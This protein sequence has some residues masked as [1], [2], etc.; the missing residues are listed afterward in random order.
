MI[1]RVTT[2]SLRAG[3]EDE[4]KGMRGFI[5]VHALN[6]MEWKQLLELSV[7]GGIDG[8]L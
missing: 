4:W 1:D 8:G 7:M 2:S 6:R 5:G 3:E